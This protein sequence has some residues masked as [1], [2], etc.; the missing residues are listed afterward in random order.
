M[1]GPPRFQRGERVLIRAGRQVMA[2]EVLLA[3][4]N[5]QSIAVGYDGMVAGCVNVLPL[6]WDPGSGTFRTIVNQEAIGVQKVTH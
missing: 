5:G 1:N 2:G 6:L 4:G 3:S